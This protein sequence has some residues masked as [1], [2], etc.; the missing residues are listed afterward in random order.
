MNQ[1]S[2][3]L[4]IWLV[5][6]TSLCLAQEEKNKPIGFFMGLEI[7]NKPDDELRTAGAS[8]K[9]SLGARFSNEKYGITA[10]IGVGFKAIKHNFIKTSYQTK[11]LTQVQENYIPVI[12]NGLEKTIAESMYAL[13][14]GNQEYNTNTSYNQFIHFSLI[15]DKVFLNPSISFNIGKDRQI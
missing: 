2:F 5:S 9:F 12:E 13:A 14:A 1:Y 11:F 15:F 10:K 3:I 7:A 6:L 4:I 8:R